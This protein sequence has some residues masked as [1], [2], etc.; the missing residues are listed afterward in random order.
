MKNK[1]KNFIALALGTASVVGTSIVS[2]AE[3]TATADSALV[4]G[5]TNAVS[6]VQANI[7]AVVPIAL[8]LMGVVLAVKIGIRVFKSVTKSSAS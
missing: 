4:T 2:F 8:G 5:A 3:D 6:Q 1:L 7:N